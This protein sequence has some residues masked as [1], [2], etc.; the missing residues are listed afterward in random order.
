MVT[1]LVS[2]KSFHHQIETTSIN[3][4]SEFQGHNKVINHKNHSNHQSPFYPMKMKTTAMVA[5]NGHTKLVSSY[6]KKDL[7]LRRFR[8]IS[9]SICL[10]HRKWHQSGRTRWIEKQRH[11]QWNPIGSW[12]IQLY[13]SRWSFVRSDLHRWWKWFPATSNVLSF[14]SI[15][16]T[17]FS[18]NRIIFFQ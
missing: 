8:I 13:R 3:I 18:D 2:Y 16:R 10:V 11:W 14:K 6:G 7:F 9:F 5:I 12:L 4:L 17:F 1:D 15:Q